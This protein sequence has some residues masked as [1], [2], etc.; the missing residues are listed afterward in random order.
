MIR[1]LNE[2]TNGLIRQYLPKGTDFASVTNENLRVIPLPLVPPPP[3]HG[4]IVNIPSPN[5]NP[6]SGGWYSR[7]TC[8]LNMNIYTVLPYYMLNLVPASIKSLRE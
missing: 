4:W 3:P 2:N 8:A 1:G 5:Y 6:K 7:C